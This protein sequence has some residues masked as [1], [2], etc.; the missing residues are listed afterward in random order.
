MNKP[1]R[2][3]R[4]WWLALFIALVVFGVLLLL[5]GDML[6]VLFRPPSQATDAPPYTA[7][8]TAA[9][10][11][12]SPT[13]TSTATPTATASPTSTPT[14]TATP[15]PTDTSTLAPTATPTSSP[16]M[17]VLPIATVTPT[18]AASAGAVTVT[19]TAVTTPTVVATAVSTVPVVTGHQIVPATPV[20]E[21]GSA[22]DNRVWVGLYGTPGSRGL[23][24]LGTA[25]ATDTVTMTIQQAYAYQTLLPGT[26]VAPFF[27]MVTTIADAH[28]GPDGDYV[29]RVSTET[30]Q[31]WIDVAR[32]HG[33]FSV[34][35][36]QPGHSP[37]ASELA[38]VEPF[39]RQPGVHLAVDPEFMMLDGVSVPGQK[40][41]SMTGELVNVVQAWLSTQAEIAGERKVLVIHQFD[42]RMFSSKEQITD[43]PLVDLV[44]D[45]DGF[46]GPGA[47]IWDYR[48]YAA[49]P[50]F[51]FGGFKLF[52][53][54][55]VPLM[56]PQQVLEL[57]PHPVFVIYQ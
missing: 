26:Q 50:G 57:V 22:F 45:A 42:D 32:A 20:A 49:E 46:G 37:I 7:A 54:Y 21:M 38:Y 24:I 41:G 17:T 15:A 27:H 29:H 56:T 30:I 33:L 8:P 43:Y 9:A 4:V 13:S 48:Q 11:A 52:Y 1:S 34:L 6:S 31:G 3:P 16:T 5:R 44:W 18:V 19:V 51:E 35:D 10:T 39:V 23:G 12:L 55:D 53:D 47:K 25:S 40:I 36:I 14:A 2:V 28:P